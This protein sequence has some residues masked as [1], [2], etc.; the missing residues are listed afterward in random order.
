MVKRMSRV[1]LNISVYHGLDCR[2]HVVIIICY[3]VRKIVLLLIFDYADQEGKRTAPLEKIQ[4]Q[5]LQV[6]QEPTFRKE[7]ARKR[8]RCVVPFGVFGSSKARKS[9]LM[10]SLVL[11]I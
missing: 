3:F 6:I 11:D 8:A 5:Q 4:S 7:N 10:I 1:P 9:F 2:Q